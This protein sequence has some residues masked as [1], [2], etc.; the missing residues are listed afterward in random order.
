MSPGRRIVIVEDDGFIAID[1]AELL[2][3]MGHE[4]CAIAG[5]E[6]EAETAAQSFHPDL[7]IV[8]GTLRNGS[9]VAAMHQI[10]KSGDIAH[11]YITGDPWRIR[12]L[13]P[14]AIIVNKPFALR[15]LEQGMA[16]ACEAARVRLNP[17]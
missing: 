8:D 12:E 17:A 6:A 5:T 16:A 3:G 14:E 7:M 13:A 10:L 4:V 9:G 2:M 15:E 11:F 1:L